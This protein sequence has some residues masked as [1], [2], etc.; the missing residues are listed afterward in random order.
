[1]TEFFHGLDYF[2]H[3]VNPL[4]GLLNTCRH[5]FQEKLKIELIHLGGEVRWQDVRL[6]RLQQFQHPM[7]IRKRLLN[8]GSQGTL[9]LFRQLLAGNIINT[10]HDGDT[11]DT[12]PKITP[13]IYLIQMIDNMEQWFVRSLPDFVE[14]AV[15]CA[16]RSYPAT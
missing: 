2:H 3:P 14:N 15:E 9:C 4:Q 5:L 7:H 8:K 6:I 16:D 10:E 1:M 11:G 12:T 13:N